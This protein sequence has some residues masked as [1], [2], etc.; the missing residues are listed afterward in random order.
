M[1]LRFGAVW[2]T[3]LALTLGCGGTNKA[4]AGARSAP[5]E[6]IPETVVT[7]LEPVPAPRELFAVAR[8]KSAAKLADVGVRWT[9]LPVDW[10]SLVA[11]ESPGLERVVAFDAPVD[12]AAE[13]DP[14]SAEP[15]VYWACAFGVASADGAAAYFQAQGNTVTRRAP[16]A[17][18]VRFEGLDCAIAPAR[19]LAPARVVCADEAGSVDA[20]TP[21]MARGL[22]TE[23]FGA[24]E[25]HAHV[26][27]EPFRRR[28]SSELALIKTM[29][30]PFLLRE[31]EIGHPKFDRALRDVVYGIADEVIALAND[32]DRI[33]LDAALS[34]R[35]DAI[36]ASLSMAMVGQRS[37]L[38]QGTV[39][40]AAASGLPPDVF[41][42]LPEDATGASYS[43]YADPEHARGLAQSLGE[44]LDGWL[45]YSELSEA[46]RRPL[47]EAFEDLFTL[48]G[49]SAFAS[50]PLASAPHTSEV[51]AKTEAARRVI[52]AHLF[53]IDHG[54]ERF[55]RFASELVKTANDRRFRE[56]LV[57][58]KLLRPDQLPTARERAP[59]GKKPLS[60][61]S[62]AFEFEFPPSAFSSEPPGAGSPEKPAAK[63]SGAVAP[64]I[65]KKAVGSRTSVVLLV[66]PDGPST[67]FAFGTD[68]SALIDRLAEV[69]A[70][71]GA[72]LALRD[73]LGPLRSEKAISAGFSSLAGVL[74]GFDTSLIPGTEGL[75][76]PRVLSRLP[77]RG[78]TV[79]L[80][81]MVAE[82]VGPK[83]SM[84]AVVP[85]AVVED[86][87]A[88]A[89]SQA[90]RTG[91]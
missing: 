36:E 27:A 85:Q 5:A 34:P 39:R 11:K 42:E 2:L 29:G 57:K 76:S 23:T 40:A 62:R 28:Y 52:G 88:I 7:P 44:L 12:C 25:V 70:G 1:E 74:P 22:P 72:T 65:A 18:A 91:W 83:L 67:W 41:W 75:G 46:R 6:T 19:G 59:K 32:V 82:A 51:D 33:D 58:T 86:I 87:V 68:E 69:K 89:V 78:E 8:V 37:W 43:S 13:L 54:G 56:H 80:W 81:S 20:L 10:R 21:Y 55:Q 50:L 9:S 64:A 73:G 31:L 61:G 14:A 16:G 3:A 15:H 79:M 47:V 24:S 38:S 26:V 48:G 77:H 4:S 60:A 53:V 49:R 66:V 71:N 63:K 45:D 35:E 84:S 90:P 30:V 17:Y